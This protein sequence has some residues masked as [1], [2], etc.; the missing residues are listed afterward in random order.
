ML[1]V[2]DILIHVNRFQ[3]KN[4]FN[5]TNIIWK[6]EFKWS[7]QII[8]VDEMSWSFRVWSSFL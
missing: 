8:I 6:K 4:E 1:I 5:I 2:C 3:P 7:T